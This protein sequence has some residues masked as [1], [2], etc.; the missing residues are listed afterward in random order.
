M[1]QNKTIPKNNRRGIRV[2]ALGSMFLR[3]TRDPETALG[4]VYLSSLKQYA[5]HGH[6]TLKMGSTGPGP[7]TTT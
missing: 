5:A 6:R 4:D 2:R 3:D 1:S 7:P